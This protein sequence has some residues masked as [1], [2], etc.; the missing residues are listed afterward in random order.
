MKVGIALVAFGLC[1]ALTAPLGAQWLDY[2]TPGIPRTPDGK[3]DL[4]APAPKSPDG[5]PD[6]SGLWMWEENRPCPPDGCADARVGEEYLNIGWSLKEGLPYQP[7][8]AAIVQ[9]TRAASR[10]NDPQIRCLPTGPI[11][12]HTFPGFRKI[13]QVPGLLVILN[14]LNATYRQIFTDGR[15]LPADPNPSWNGYSSGRWVG[16]T[17][18]VETTGL[19]DGLWLDTGGSPLTDAARITERFRRV[20]FGKLEVEITVDDPKAYTRPWTI[21]LTQPL[22]P[23][24]EMI[25]YICQENEKDVPHLPK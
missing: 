11:R 12:L 23:D 18:V 24:T 25:D 4:S 8:A 20:N 6:L 5:R 22:Q 3:P 19:R 21:K 2:P 7:W 17:L 14:E 15:P 9:A 10:P 13:V 16:D 1:V